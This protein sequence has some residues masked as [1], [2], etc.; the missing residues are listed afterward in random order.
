MCYRQLYNEVGLCQNTFFF[1]Y[2]LNNYIV[3]SVDIAA[4]HAIVKIVSNDNIFTLTMQN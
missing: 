2:F 1:Y 3:V 4:G